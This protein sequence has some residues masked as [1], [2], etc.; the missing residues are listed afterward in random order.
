MFTDM[1]QTD[2]Q[3]FRQA[4]VASS[5]SFVPV[6]AE[7]GAMGGVVWTA[8]ASRWGDSETLVGPWPPP[9]QGKQAR[10]LKWTAFVRDGHLIMRQDNGNDVRCATRIGHSSSVFNLPHHCNNVPAILQ[11][12]L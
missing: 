1:A 7:R 8:P 6:W 5:H 10:F 11:I 3:A 9:T 2:R 12:Q 4:E